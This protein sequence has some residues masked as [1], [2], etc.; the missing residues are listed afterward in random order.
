MDYSLYPKYKLFYKQIPKLKRVTSNTI[1]YMIAR[2]L[3]SRLY[4]TY[5]SMVMIIIGIA[6]KLNLVA[7]CSIVSNFSV[8]DLSGGTLTVRVSFHSLYMV[9]YVA[10]FC[11][12]N[13]HGV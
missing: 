5:D 13:L 12:S 8:S 11:I 1:N 4:A 9:M 10:F 7:Y 2:E 3:N 6:H